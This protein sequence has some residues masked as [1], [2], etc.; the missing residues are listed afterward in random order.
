MVSDAEVVVI[1]HQAGDIFRIGRVSVAR[2]T[3]SV[4]RD[5]AELFGECA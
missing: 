2:L 5:I 3:K 1:R 4:R